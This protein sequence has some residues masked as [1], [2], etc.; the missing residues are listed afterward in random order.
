MKGGIYIRRIPIEDF[1][2]LEDYLYAAREYVKIPAA[3]C[4]LIDKCALSYDFMLAIVKVGKRMLLLSECGTGSSGYVFCET[5]LIM[6]LNYASIEEALTDTHWNEPLQKE[7][8]EIDSLA[9][10]LYCDLR[11]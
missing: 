8:R 9:Y 2:G 7:I 6:E 5:K 4:L 1:S 10:G 11:R 3:N